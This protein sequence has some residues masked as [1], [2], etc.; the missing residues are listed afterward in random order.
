VDEDIHS[1]YKLPTISL[2]TD[3]YFLF[4]PLIGIYYAEN[5]ENRGEK[6]ER[7][8]HLEY[9]GVGGLPSYAKSTDIRLNGEWTRQYPQ[10]S[11]RLYAEVDYESG[12]QFTFDFFG[13]EKW[14][15]GIDLLILRNSGQDWYRALMRD[16]LVQNLATQ[17]DLDTQAQRPV[18]V[19]I[20][21]EY[22]GIH[23]LVE[24]Y[25]ENYFTRHYEVDPENLVAL[26][27]QGMLRIGEDEDAENYRAK[28][29]DLHSMDPMDAKTFTAISDW[30]DLDNFI[31]YQVLEIY[32]ANWD[33]P[34]NDI[35]YWRA[36]NPDGLNGVNEHLDGRWRWLVQDVDAGFLSADYKS[37]EPAI[38]EANYLLKWMLQN[39]GFREQFLKRFAD[40]L[41]STFTS[42]HVILEINNFEARLDPEMEE[43]IQRWRFPYGNV[44]HWYTEVDQLRSFAQEQPAKMRKMLVNYFRLAGIAQLKVEADQ[45]QGYI[46]VNSLEIQA[47]EIGVETPGQW[48]GIYFMDVPITLSAHPREGYRF[49]HWEGEGVEGE[50]A[51]TITL[52]L[53][54]DLSI[55]A[56]F[57]EGD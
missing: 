40:L 39:P 13:N 25:N 37:L 55:K 12:D 46:H 27:Y 35:S 38:S 21:G 42:A 5:A 1:R 6:W 10:K 41:N 7:P 44:E 49:S 30:M 45:T 56:V 32:S 20:N 34:T 57:T 53:D 15:A 19:F 54:G 26:E 3:A 36:K 47:R 14:G 33:W 48:E 28:L 17:I 43:H 52:R 8:A 24:S 9:F 50:T 4:D 16:A 11:L 29:E 51:P 22:W 18:V 31:D 23:L 2:V